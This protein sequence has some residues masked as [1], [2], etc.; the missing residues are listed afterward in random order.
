MT[1]GTRRVVGEVEGEETLDR[2]MHRM[3]KGLKGECHE[4]EKG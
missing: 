4:S 1:T 2:G 3:V